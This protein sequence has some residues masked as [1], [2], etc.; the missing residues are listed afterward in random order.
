MP[1]WT[2]D[3]NVERLQHW[4]SAIVKTLIICSTKYLQSADQNWITQYYE[5]NYIICLSLYSQQY[6]ITLKPSCFRCFFI[7]V[8][9][10]WVQSLFG[11]FCCGTSTWLFIVWIVFLTLILNEDF[12]YLHVGN[13]VGL[14]VAL[15]FFVVSTVLLLLCLVVVLLLVLYRNKRQRYI[16]L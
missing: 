3:C 11:D 9:S 2:S 1:C 4:M 8:V 16:S 10:A 5:I 7:V 12:S 14:S 15:G 13:V 6:P